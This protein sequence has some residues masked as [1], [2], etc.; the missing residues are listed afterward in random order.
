[1]S[2]HE[3]GHVTVACPAEQVALPMAGNGA[4]LD[5]RRPF[6]DRD[7][8]DDP[9]LGVAVNA[10][11][12]RTADPP[13]RARC[14]TNSCSALRALEKQ[15]AVDSF[16]GHAQALVIQIL[17]LQ[18]PGNLFRRPVLNQFTRNH[19]RSLLV[20]ARRHALGRKADSQAW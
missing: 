13:L 9:T 1:M 18:P 4:I 19:L 17:H 7:G 8:I 20:V 14:F 2:L 12:L 6:P 15:A 5:F 10:G 11:V 3:G 16:V